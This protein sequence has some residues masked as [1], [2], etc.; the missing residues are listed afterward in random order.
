MR[1]EHGGGACELR[2]MR[3]SASGIAHPQWNVG[4]VTAADA[5]IEGARVFFAARGVPWGCASRLACHGRTGGCCPQRLMGL[6]AAEHR[7]ARGVPG[8][9]LRAAVLADV[10]TVVRIDAEAFGEEPELERR[11][12]EPHLYAPRCTVALAELDGAP[13]GTGYPLRSD[14]RAGPCLDVA[15]VAVAA[16]ARRR[17]VAARTTSWL[18]DRGFAA[19]RS[20]RTCIPTPTLPR[21]CTPGSGSSRRPASTSTSTCERPPSPCSPNM[22]LAHRHFPRAR[23]SASPRSLGADACAAPWRVDAL[24]FV[25]AAGAQ[26]RRACADGAGR[27]TS[28]FPASREAVVS[29]GCQADGGRLLDSSKRGIRASHTSFWSSVVGSASAASVATQRWGLTV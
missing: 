19:A 14:G 16:A 6:H 1:V 7:P 28:A 12:L 4:D 23:S 8:L 18:L 9:S 21:A 17:G 3:L 10:S 15:G 27:A 24:V 26:R 22:A 29:W 2:G 25:T 13:A 5:D 11:W 20:S